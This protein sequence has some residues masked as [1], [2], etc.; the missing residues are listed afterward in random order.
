LEWR[1]QRK[2]KDEATFSSLNLSESDKQTIAYTLNETLNRNFNDSLQ[3]A[4]ATSQEKAQ[5]LFSATTQDFLIADNSDQ[6]FQFN[7]II[8]QLKEIEALIGKTNENGLLKLVGDIC[9]FQCGNKG[10]KGCRPK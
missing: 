3:L 5:Q 6:T 2:S 1:T 8:S 7:A 10:N 4:F 9:E